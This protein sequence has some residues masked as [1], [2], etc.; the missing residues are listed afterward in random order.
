MQSSIHVEKVSDAKA[1]VGTLLT[2]RKLVQVEAYSEAMRAD[3]SKKAF[4]DAFRE[5]GVTRLSF[6]VQR[7]PD[8][9]LVRWEGAD[10]DSVLLRYGNSPNRELSRWRGLLRVFSGPDEADGYWDASRERIFS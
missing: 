5:I 4:G 9:S 2:Y 7:D 1:E 3:V 10:I 8:A 6:W